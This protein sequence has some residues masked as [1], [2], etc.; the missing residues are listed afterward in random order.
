MVKLM[1]CIISGMKC[2][3]IERVKYSTLRWFWCIE[4]MPDIELLKIIYMRRVDVVNA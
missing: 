3:V 2:G 1:K 4:I